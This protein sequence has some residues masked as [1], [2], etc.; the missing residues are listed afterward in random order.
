MERSIA[1]RLHKVRE[2]NFK[3]LGMSG[4]S[5]V[6]VFVV[7]V[8]AVVVFTKTDLWQ[9]AVKGGLPSISTV[10]ISSCEPPVSLTKGALRMKQRFNAYLRILIGKNIWMWSLTHKIKERKEIISLLMF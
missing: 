9:N 10:Y 6:V 1:F 3:K 8:V 7:V 5:F 4:V 2:K